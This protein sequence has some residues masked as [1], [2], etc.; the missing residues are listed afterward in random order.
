MK[1]SLRVV[2]LAVFCFSYPALQ[3][4]ELIDLTLIKNGWVST[5]KN[6]DGSAKQAG[7]LIK[8]STLL[9]PNEAGYVVE[10]RPLLVSRGAK[11]EEATDV[12]VQAKSTA[13][14][15]H[16]E[17]AQRL[18]IRTKISREITKEQGILSTTIGIPFGEMDL[19][20][21]TYQLFYEVTVIVQ[22]DRGQ[23]KETLTGAT[24]LTTLSVEEGT[25]TEL[26][27]PIQAP[28]QVIY[29]EAPVKGYV[30]TDGELVERMGKRITQTV[31]AATKQ[32]AVEKVNIPGKF[33]RGELPAE[34]KQP[35]ASLNQFTLEKD[36][37]IRFAT[38]RNL[39]DYKNLKTPFG[40][41]LAPQITYGQC[42]VNIPIANHKTGQLKKPGWFG[43]KPEEHFYVEKVNELDKQLFYQSIA[44][45]DILVY[46]HG[47]A[48][49]FVS[50]M[51]TAA[52]IQHDLQFGGKLLAFTW[53]SE[54]SANL[55]AYQR[56]GK[57]SA[58]SYQALA[59]VLAPLI[60][61]ART[62]KKTLS[63]IAHSMGNRV[64]L[65]ALNHLI[66]TKTVAV[67]EKAF[68]HL[69]LAA[70][71]VDVNKFGS[72][73]AKISPFTKEITFYYSNEDVAL[74]V[75]AKVQDPNRAGLYPV[76]L[77]G[78]TTINVD[79]VNSSYSPVL[80]YGHSYYQ[81]SDRVLMDINLNVIKGL[82]ADQRRPPLAPPKEL[83]G[84]EGFPH[85]TFQ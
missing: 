24:K 78:M 59:E 44:H 45:N 13:D 58:E 61:Q 2:F 47:F 1:W 84:F 39:I 26:L 55:A 16:I 85:Y 3:A 43:K 36:R 12:P 37:V 83:E 52:Q 6:N 62:Q 25:R 48:N 18:V 66:D 72:Y 81:G 63:L 32:P 75:S 35:S 80:T 79:Q 17:E 71:D 9:E 64:L 73:L 31:S 60:V 82:G 76:F 50:A 42:V 38:N 65:R 46:I 54:G 23:T 5:E 49:N 7:D 77:N 40:D 20:I 34:Q 56:D 67:G 41:Q 33:V 27:R 70:P 69:V 29:G 28:P 68:D 53:P 51:I 22:D 14:K 15:T 10:V 30:L 74:G 19:N 21:G 11:G 4:A 8:I 57:K